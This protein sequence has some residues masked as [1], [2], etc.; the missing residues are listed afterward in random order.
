MRRQLTHTGDENNVPVEAESVDQVRTA[1]TGPRAETATRAAVLIER[2]MTRG[3]VWSRRTPPAKATITLPILRQ[4]LEKRVA[5]RTCLLAGS[6]SRAKWFPATGHASTSSRRQRVA[7]EHSL[8]DGKEPELSPPATRACR[9]PEDRGDGQ[10]ETRRKIERE[11][12][13]V[14]GDNAG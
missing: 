3:R 9:L 12:T 1:K 14:H 7:A 5:N 11:L 8:M 10:G 4:L 2:A 6:R 13:N